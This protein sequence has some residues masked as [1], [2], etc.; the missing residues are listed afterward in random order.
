MRQ[1][2]ALDT[3]LLIKLSPDVQRTM[4]RHLQAAQRIK[5]KGEL[6]LLVLTPRIRVLLEKLTVTQLVKF[7]AFYGTRRFITV[8]TGPF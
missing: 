4:K 2:E 5:Q 7:L 3:G 8:F 1:L 6:M